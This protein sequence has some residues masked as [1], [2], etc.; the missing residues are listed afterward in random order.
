L[1][2]SHELG[3]IE[4]GK[5]ADIANAFEDLRG[6]GPPLA[7]AAMKQGLSF[8]HV[9]AADRQGMTP[10]KTEVAVDGLTKDGDSVPIL[11]EDVWQ[12]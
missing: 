8:H 1:G 2:V 10:E 3:S 11:R 12:L 4:A 5:L 6:S 7:E 9:A